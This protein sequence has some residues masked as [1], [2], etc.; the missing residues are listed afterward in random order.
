M[1]KLWQVLIILIICAG[2]TVANY[3]MLGT[4]AERTKQTKAEQA[5]RDAQVQELDRKIKNLDKR[6]STLEDQHEKTIW[7]LQ[8]VDQRLIAVQEGRKPWA[9]TE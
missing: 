1:K 5:S 2:F 3:I 9:S 8:D 4:Q 6:V 7:I